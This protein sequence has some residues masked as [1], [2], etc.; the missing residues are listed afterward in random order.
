MS[1]YL[2]SPWCVSAT[3]SLSH[4]GQSAKVCLYLHYYYRTYPLHYTTLLLIGKL[5]SIYSLFLYTL[6]I[7]TPS[8]RNVEV[9][10][11]FADVYSREGNYSHSHV[12]PDDLHVSQPSSGNGRHQCKDLFCRP[13]TLT[14]IFHQQTTSHQMF[15][16]CPV[17]VGK[18]VGTWGYM[19]S[20]AKQF[21]WDAANQHSCGASVPRSSFFLGWFKC[22]DTMVPNFARLHAS[23]YK[24][25]QHAGPWFLLLSVLIFHVTCRNS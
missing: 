9:E 12:I 8:L 24:T 2:Q 25:A 19:W 11:V 6:F 5:G 22:T 16:R 14:R 13:R 3:C 10:S 7:L 20:P 4:N 21:S 23:F 17:F 18:R 15:T 1:V